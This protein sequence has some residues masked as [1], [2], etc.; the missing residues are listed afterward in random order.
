MPEQYTGFDKED[1]EQYGGQSTPPHFRNRGKD[2]DS[3]NQSA[4][5]SAKGAGVPGKLILLRSLLKLLHMLTH[6]TLYV[7]RPLHRR[8]LGQHP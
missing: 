8:L 6:D 1:R 2:G 3:S 7:C 4:R 5:D